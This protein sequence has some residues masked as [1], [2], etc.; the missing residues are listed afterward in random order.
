MS[1]DWYGDAMLAR[2]RQGAMQGVV[3]AIGIVEKRAVDL[4]LNTPKTGRVYTT[5]F[6]T[7]GRGRNRRVI[8]YGSRPA[9]QASAPGEPPAS[10]T[11][12]LVNN[13]RIDLISERLAAR[14][15]FSSKYAVYL[16]FGTDR[17]EPRPWADR[18]LRE[19]GDEI[20]NAIISNVRAAI[21]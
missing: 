14:L 6:Y 7:V 1:V 3:D 12:N 8:A 2:M 10:D 19:S 15:V 4:I 5:R 9:H 11:G 20:N 13:R 17:T 16:Q 21:T 18:A